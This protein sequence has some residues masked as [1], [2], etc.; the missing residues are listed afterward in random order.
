MK[1]LNYFKEH[2]FLIFILLIATFLRFYHLDFQSIWLD[3][4]HTMIESNP[5]LTFDEFKEVITFREG[6][7][8]F[9]FL[10]VRNLHTIF[11]FSTYTARMYS[12]ILGVASVYG[13]YILGKILYNKNVGLI[14]ASLLC[15][16]FFSIFYSQEARPYMLLMLVTIISFIRLIIF[17]RNQTIKNAIWFGIATGLIVNTHFVG[18]T[19]IFSQYVLL[20]FLFLLTEKNKTPQ[21]KNLFHL[22]K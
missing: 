1:T 19:T 18:L 12:A 10:T 5:K 13:I 15:V 2:F 3:E 11:G 6:M 9:Y 22:R 4:I 17:V 20:L 14:A 7:G 16:N 8:Y 21:S